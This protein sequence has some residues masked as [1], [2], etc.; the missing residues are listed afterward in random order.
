MDVDRAPRSEVDGRLEVLHVSES[1]GEAFYGHDLAL[2]AFGHAGSDSVFFVAVEPQVARLFQTRISPTSE[3]L[4]FLAA[5]LVEHLVTP[6]VDNPNLIGIQIGDGQNVWGQESNFT[7][8]YS[9]SNPGSGSH[10]KLTDTRGRKRGMM[11]RWLMA[12][13]MVSANV[14][15][16]ATLV[17]YR[18]EEGLESTEPQVL[19]DSGPHGLHGT[20]VGPSTAWEVEPPPFVEAGEQSCYLRPGGTIGVVPYDPV[21]TVSESFTVEFFF[22][23]GF[24]TPEEDH[25]TYPILSQSLG[26]STSG[27]KAWSFEYQPCRQEVRATL[28]FTDGTTFTMPVRFHQD[29]PGRWH[30]LALVHHRELDGA[31]TRL[32]LDGGLVA[33]SRL[34]E[35]RPPV[36]GEGSLLLGGDHPATTQDPPLNVGGIFDEIRISNIALNPAQFVVD[37]SPK[38]LMTTVTPAMEI[39][40]PSRSDTLYQVQYSTS[41]EPGEWANVEDGLVFG[42]GFT[43]TMLDRNVWS[44]RRFYRVE[45]VE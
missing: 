28:W 20:V 26:E 9:R 16:G 14:A 1:S 36:A 10:I 11:M 6:Q 42:D 4:G 17:H 19:T 25:R 39:S 21:M 30:H 38:P 37:L 23:R 32:F 12:L 45:A 41:M 24:S 15:F 43:K 33:S 2:D 7:F 31:S 22:K 35:Q 8:G 3:P 18:F 29:P 13:A 40:W 27:D 5:N 44:G 34:R